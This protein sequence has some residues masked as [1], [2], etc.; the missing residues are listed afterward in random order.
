MQP[1]CWGKPDDMPTQRVT[2]RSRP[3]QYLVI[4][5]VMVA[6]VLASILLVLYSAERG[7]DASV[8]VAAAVATGALSGSACA[9]GWRRDRG[10]AV[11]ADERGLR[12]SSRH[13]DGRLSWGDLSDIGW[14]VPTQYTKGGLA[15]RL[16]ESQPGPYDLARWLC[17]PSG[18][19]RPP[20]VEALKALA[21][22]AGVRWHDYARMDVSNASR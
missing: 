22:A 5:P 11:V 4:P 8:L 20:E 7:P 19:I 10:E 2:L 1:A 13:G 17:S 12:I 6:F 3:W 16:A 18:V 9:Y 21:T 14:V 15:G